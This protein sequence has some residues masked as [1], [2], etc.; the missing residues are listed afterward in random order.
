M[1]AKPN[2]ERVAQL[3]HSRSERVIAP[4]SLRS[5]SS[6]VFS[7]VCSTTTREEPTVTIAS[8]TRCHNSWCS[9]SATATLSRCSRSLIPRSTR[10]LSFSDRAAGRYSS[11]DNRAIARVDEDTPLAYRCRHLFDRKRLDDITDFYIRESFESHTELKARF[12]FV[13]IILESTQRADPAFVDDD[14]VPH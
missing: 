7:S 5:I 13:H 6:S 14:A 11:K 8:P 12:D 9:T 10:R 3:S 1:L 2:R 4:G